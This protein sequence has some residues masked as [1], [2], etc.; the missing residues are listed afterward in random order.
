MNEKDEVI[1]HVRRYRKQ[2]SELTQQQLADKVGVSRQ[3]IL[4]IESGRYNP[5][6]GLA[7]RIAEVFS[8]PVEEL[9]QIN[10]DEL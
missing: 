2:M 6:V 8:V 5:S 3:T 7:I 4:S 9:F 1:N 10:R